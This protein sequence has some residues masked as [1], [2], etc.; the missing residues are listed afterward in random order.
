MPGTERFTVSCRADASPRGDERSEIARERA[1][2]H[3]T[4]ARV[5]GSR[6]KGCL[7]V[8]PV[9]ARS[10]AVFGRSAGRRVERPDR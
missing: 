5:V 7:R 2:A 3:R 8:Q 9:C 6:A 4:K 1:N 10:E